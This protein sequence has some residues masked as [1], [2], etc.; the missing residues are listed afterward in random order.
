MAL[1][2]T[3][4]AMV[5]YRSAG[6]A[7]RDGDG[8]AFW[9]RLQVLPVGQNAADAEGKALEFELPVVCQAERE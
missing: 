4:C 6:D 9:C 3:E 2:L 8:E 5:Q 7:E 1:V